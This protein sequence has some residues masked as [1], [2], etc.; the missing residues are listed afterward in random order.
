MNNQPYK[1]K[2]RFELYVLLASG[3]TV[4][5][6]EHDNGVVSFCFKD[7]ALC[8]DILFKLFNKELVLPM[9]DVIEA[10]RNTQ[11]IFSKYRSKNF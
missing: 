10:I 2:D 9:H 1:T 6:L 5:S 11:S 4:Q 7:E 8:K 3:C